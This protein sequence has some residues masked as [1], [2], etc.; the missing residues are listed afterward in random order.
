MIAFL[1]TAI[2]KSMFL[3]QMNFKKKSISLRFIVFN[4]LKN[5]LTNIYMFLEY[6]AGY[7]NIV[8]R[9]QKK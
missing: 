6:K 3:S 8:T 2:R 5:T 7:F 1:D 4:I 9:N